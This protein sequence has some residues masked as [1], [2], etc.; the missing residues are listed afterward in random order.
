LLAAAEAIGAA[1]RVLDEARGYAAERRQFGRSIGS[2]QSLRHLLADMYVRAASGWSTVLYAAAAF[3]EGAQDAGH[4]ASIA[5]AYVSRGA[6]EV[7]HGA[8]QVFGGIA[9]TAEHPAHRWLRRISV[10]E[11]Q[12]G[13]GAHHERALG[14]ALAER[15]V[16]TAP[17]LGEASVA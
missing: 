15:C 7:A 12:F 11:Q 17:A 9:F 14:R 6:R 2:F 5:K 8:I 4:T 13:D 3:D 16:R 1:G 10:R